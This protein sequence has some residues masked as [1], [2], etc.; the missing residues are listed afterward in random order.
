[1]KTGRTFKCLKATA[2]RF[3]MGLSQHFEEDATVCCFLSRVRAV[4]KPTSYSASYRHA[5]TG[6]FTQSLLFTSFGIPRVSPPW[7]IQDDVS[8]SLVG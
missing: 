4:T 5:D 3:G 1:M 6:G 7:L 2:I 8:G